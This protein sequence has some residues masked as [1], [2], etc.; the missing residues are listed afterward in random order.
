MGKGLGFGGFQ[1]DLS[2]P[3]QDRLRE[4]VKKK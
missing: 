4:G 3:I 2:D 1:N